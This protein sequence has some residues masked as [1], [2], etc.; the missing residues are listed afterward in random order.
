MVSLKK[1]NNTPQMRTIKKVFFD[2]KILFY[3]DYELS[4][5][6]II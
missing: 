4:K 2:L 6:N 5:K 3:N 1:N